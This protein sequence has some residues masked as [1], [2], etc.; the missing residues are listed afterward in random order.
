MTREQTSGDTTIGHEL[1][2]R[3]RLGES[4]TVYACSELLS[5]RDT[6]LEAV[7]A[8]PYAALH[9]SR[10]ATS[11]SLDIT[12]QASGHSVLMGCIRNAYTTRKTCINPSEFNELTND[13][14]QLVRPEVSGGTGRIGFIWMLMLGQSN[15]CAHTGPTNFDSLIC[16]TAAATPEFGCDLTFSPEGAALNSIGT[17]DVAIRNAGNALFHE[18]G[19]ALAPLLHQGSETRSIDMDAKPA[20]VT[21]NSGSEKPLSRRQLL[22]LR[23]PPRSAI[24]AI[25]DR[26]RAKPDPWLDDEHDWPPQG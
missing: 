10:T 22:Q 7:W 19:H 9:Y 16:K 25:I 15:A 4:A 1:T 6:R 23:M 2:R 8:L 12:H 5:G 24:K 14:A 21:A 3:Y 11:V 26:R 20:P 13:Y 17:F 18:P